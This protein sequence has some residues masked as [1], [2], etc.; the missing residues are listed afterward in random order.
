MDQRI[1]L[2]RTI[3]PHGSPPPAPGARTVWQ[4]WTSA[5]HRVMF[6]LG[7]TQI[8][9]TLAWW[10]VDLAGRFGGLY[11]PFSWTVPRAWAHAFLMLYTVF[12]LFVLG[13]TMTAMPNWTSQRLPRR[14]WVSTA[15]PIALGIPLIYAGI[16]LHRTV[17][18]V[19]VTLLLLGWAAG[20]SALARLVIGNRAKD[21]HALGIL[22][23]LA[24]GALCIAAFDLSLYT[25]DWRY[26]DFSRQAGM[27]LF[28]LPLFMI[29]SH[30]LVPFFSSRIIQNYAMYRPRGSLILLSVGCLTHFALEWNALMQ[31]TWLVDLPMAAWVG[32][33]A[34]RWG[35]AKS[36]RVKLLTMLHMSLIT[37]AIALAL[38]G[39]A[40]VASLLGHPALFGLAPL[41]A[42]AIGYFTAMT[43]A[44]VSRVTLGHS[45]RA[46]EADPMTWRCYQSVLVIAA[47][48]VLGDFTVIPAAA[49]T[50]LLLLAAI[51]W[52]VVFTP[53]SAR[54]APIYLRPRAD[55]KPG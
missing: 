33:L 15:I 34:L 49:R 40:S 17:A 31:W 43:V 36:F 51:A 55:G 54:Y 37:L 28:L 30:R 52:L 32:Y 16:A 14:A 20:W 38:Y 8:V 12:P 24:I 11:A 9:A 19:G 53:W 47:I 18:A 25:G 23:I 45:G 1:T 3:G 42:L 50:A 6:L 48:R 22:I 26:A 44:M 4:V 13:F 2:H 27:W 46:L 10:L 29:V 39:V 21:K 35:L 7:V 41:H 5:P